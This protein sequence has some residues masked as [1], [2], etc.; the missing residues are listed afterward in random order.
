M[1]KIT[2]EA[3][4]C[5][6]SSE[7]DRIIAQPQKELAG[8]VYGF[9]GVL[10]FSLTL[11]ATRMAISGFDPICVRLVRAIVAA[12]L[13]LLLL[14][15]TRQPIP[16]LRFLLRVCIVVAGVIIGFPLLSAI[17]MLD[18]PASHGAVITP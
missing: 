12:G 18:A 3:E 8:F 4:T 1:F 16:L 6:T 5:E 9:L 11:P 7:K 14:V 17:A 13:A 15:A 2:I 10:V